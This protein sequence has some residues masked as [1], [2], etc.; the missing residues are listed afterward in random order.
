MSIVDKNEVIIWHEFDGK[1][2]TTLRLLEDIT[3][4]V[5][6]RTN[7]NFKLKMM[8][9]VDFI[10]GLSAI[11][12]TKNGPHMAFIPS[13]L[14]VFAEKGLFSEVPEL[15]FNGYADKKIYE[16][17]SYKGKQYGVPILGGNNEVI[18][19]NKKI[20][21][22]IPKDFEDLRKMKAGFEE[23]GII[24]IAVDMEIPYW[25]IPFLSAF[26]GWPIKDKNLEL[27][28]E[29][30]KETFSFLREQ[31]QE[32]IIVHYKATDAMLSNFIDGKIACMMNGEWVYNYLLEECEDILGVCLIP[33]IRGKQA[34]VT[35]STIGW[36][37]PCDSLESEYKKPIMELVKYMMSDECQLRLLNGVNRIP[38]NKKIIE[39]VKQNGSET[40][41]GILEQLN[42]SETIPVNFKMRE[43]WDD[44]ENGLKMLK[45]NSISID[46]IVKTVMYKK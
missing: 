15:L 6:E 39:E 7:V 43:I 30:L 4:E 44:I 16:T 45:N 25:F 40:K 24:P 27:D 33:T 31:I 17:M 20:L 14:T 29:A 46:D 23:K 10:K 18:Y 9:I 22:D 37:F 36:V 38:V 5:S 32:G 11:H 3:R 35:T 19:Y 2:D 28:Y 26:G 13:D 8:N 21:K 34:K 41:K 1:A 42:F 12:K